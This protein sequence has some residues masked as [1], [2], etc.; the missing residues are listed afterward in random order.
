MDR[1]LHRDEPRDGTHVGHSTDEVPQRAAYRR[2]R[3]LMAVE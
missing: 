1:G 2:W 3:E